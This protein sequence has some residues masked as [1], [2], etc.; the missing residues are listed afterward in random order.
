[1]Q[2]SFQRREFH[3]WNVCFLFSIINS[4]DFLVEKMVKKNNKNNFSYR[5]NILTIMKKSIIQTKLLCF[6]A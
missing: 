2:S 3:T 4:F 1:M 5:K 6:L